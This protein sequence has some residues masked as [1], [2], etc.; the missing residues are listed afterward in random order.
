MSLQVPSIILPTMGLAPYVLYIGNE[1]E[2][3]ADLVTHVS[4]EFRTDSISTKTI[5]IVAVEDVAAGVPGALLCWVEL[6]PYPTITSG[7][8]WAAIGGGGGSLAPTAPVTI[9]ATGV[10][11]TSHSF[12]LPWNVYSKYARLVV[13]TPVAAGLPAAFWGIQAM[14]SGKD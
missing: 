12:F 9:A 2:T 6:S 10:N 1:T 5:H 11:G 8:Y 3:V 14:V 7:A 4:L 13:Q